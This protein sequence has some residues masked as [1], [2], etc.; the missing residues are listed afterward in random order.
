MLKIEKKYSCI[1]DPVAHIYD[2]EGMKKNPI[3][4][5]KF[6]APWTSSFNPKGILERLKDT[7][8]KEKS[9]FLSRYLNK[10]FEVET[11]YEWSVSGPWGTKIH[12]LLDLL[13]TGRITK[14]DFID[15]KKFNKDIE[16]PSQVIEGSHL[17]KTLLDKGWKVFASELTLGAVFNKKGEVVPREEIKNYK[18]SELLTIAGALDIVLTKENKLAVLDWK[19]SR[20]IDESA[21]RK[22]DKRFFKIPFSDIEETKKNK[23]SCQVAVGRKLCEI[24]F[25]E[26][27][28]IDKST[29]FFIP[30]IDNPKGQ[31]DASIIPIDDA[32]ET[33][34]KMLKMYLKK[35]K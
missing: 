7:A 8:V 20:K 28:V 29:L 14:K 1:L 32:M 23:Y 25:P 34:D 33:I 15:A 16:L 18:E 27:E 6:V 35:L 5:T 13:V 3:S 9:Y 2:L 17:L 11:E 24:N 4:S 31:P 30:P 19:T 22:E 21:T 10:V 12:D 26:Y